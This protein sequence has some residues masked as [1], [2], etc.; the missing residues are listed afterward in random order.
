[1]GSRVGA[2]KPRQNQASPTGFEPPAQLHVTPTRKFQKFQSIRW[3]TLDPA[4][5]A[6]GPDRPETSRK[7]RNGF[8]IRRHRTL[9]KGA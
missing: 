3:R 4:S 8:A 5:E 9:H 1:M 6:R 7:N 2:E